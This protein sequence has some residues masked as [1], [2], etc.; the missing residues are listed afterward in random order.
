MTE[1]TQD[2]PAVGPLSAGDW[3]KHNGSCVQ[4][5]GQRVDVRKADGSEWL[6]WI[7]DQW[8]LDWIWHTGEERA[9]SD[10]VEFRL[11]SLAP[12]APVEASGQDDDLKLI[13]AHTIIEDLRVQHP[14]IEQI[15]NERGD[16]WLPG[17]STPQS[18]GCIVDIHSVAQSVEQQVL[19]ALRPG[20]TDLMVSPESIDA[21]LEA[22][23]PPVEAGGSERDGYVTAFYEI[24]D[25]L[26]IGAQAASPA[27]V[28]S[29]QMRPRLEASL[30]PQPSGETREAVAARIRRLV[31]L[32]DADFSFVAREA[33]VS[34]ETD[35]I[36]ALLRPAAPGGGETVLTNGDQIK[37]R[38]QLRKFQ[39]I[40]EHDGHVWV[41][42][43]NGDYEG[44]LLTFRADTLSAIP[45]S[46]GG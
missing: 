1:A 8:G 45:A 38:G 17:G 37:P 23:P 30:R 19:A 36:L 27:E 44:E 4:A 6:D 24:A 14:G 9:P 21:F 25:M 10:I 32:A 2:K 5:R 7:A 41:K 16:I 35:A 46:E 20:H 18:S 12:T 15:D 43:L 3:T 31:S 22:N 34:K 26:G 11:S 29:R 40:A 42:A 39:R 13:I 28:W 33:Y